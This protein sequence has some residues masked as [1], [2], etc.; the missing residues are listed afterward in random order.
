[1]VRVLFALVLIIHGL[2]HIFGF[3]KLLNEGQESPL[4]QQVSKPVSTILWLLATGLFVTTAILF[5]IKSSHWLT[6][7]FISLMVSQLLIF[8]AWR[9]AK[10]GTLLNIF[11]LL[12]AIVVY[13]SRQFQGV[14]EE[15]VLSSIQRTKG[16]FNKILREEDMVHLPEPVRKYLHY[17][18]VIGK[19]R[20]RNFKVNFSGE[21][22]SEG[23]N[24]FPF[25]SEQHNFTDQPERFFFMKAKVNGLPTNG[26]HRYQGDQAGMDIKLLSMFTVAELT[27]EPEAF[28]AETVT[29]LNDMC[30]LAP[31]TLID[32][33]IEWD[34]ISPLKV[35]ATF[36]N[37]NIRV[38]AILH[39]NQEGQ[40]VNFVS[41]DRYALTENG[42]ENYR[43]STPV[44][45]YK[46]INGVNL[47]TYGE[48][49]WHYPEGKFT[50]GK[51]FLKNVQYNI[52]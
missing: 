4:S 43:F 13:N 6:L 32:E 17:T 52:Q 14:Y 31:A 10:Y 50:Y 28:Q 21:M 37:Q 16:E 48:A 29:L 51:F 47:P 12:I 30:L 20:V 36:T 23:Q 49:I 24:W 44:S 46:A 26:Y 27:N 34:S 35:E 40:L 45:D 39:F 2:I 7:A 25:S 41:D 11:I 8:T 19:P 15:D 5:F 9:D 1:M 33:R 22:R 3:S 42:L 18:G 38:S